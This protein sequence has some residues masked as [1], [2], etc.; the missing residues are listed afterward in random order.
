MSLISD[1]PGPSAVGENPRARAWAWAR[2]HEYRN[3]A[4]ALLAIFAA[5]PLLPRTLPFGLYVLGGVSAAGMILNGL[6]VALVY[7]VNRFPNFA[8]VALAAFAGTVFSS[9]VRGQFFLDVARS[10]CGCV[11]RD[12]KGISVTVNFLLAVVVGMATATAVSFGF[13]VIVLRRFGRASRLLL[14]VFTLFAAQL[15]SYSEG[16]VARLL[17]VEATLEG[18]ERI[19]VPVDFEWT[20]D[21]FA[22]LHLRDVLLV[23]LAVVAL[24]G[25]ARYLR[26]SD[27]G[28]AVNAASENPDRARSLGVDVVAVTSRVWILAGLLA[29]AAGVVGA[30]G[31]TTE[32][33]LG[34]LKGLVTLLFVAVVARFRS[35]AMLACAALVMGTLELAV[36]YSFGSR[37]P[38]D[39]VGVFLIGGVL[40][41]QRVRR[42]RADRDDASGFEVARE[43]RPIPAELRGL[44]Q[45]RAWVRNG[46][47]AGVLVLLGL[48]W[49]F[50]GRRTAEFTVFVIF[51]IVGL[52]LV[53]VTAWMGQ[54]SLGQFGFAA[55]GAWGAAVSGL[56][57]P[58]AVVV[59]GFL[60]AVAA[61]VVGLPALRLGGLTLA[62]STLAFATSAN[63]LFTGDRYLGQLLPATLERPRLLG[64]DLVDPRVFYYAMV[65]LT[66]ATAVGVMG[67]RRSHLGRALIGL[68]SNEAAGE[69][70]GLDPVRLRLTA[71]AISGFLAAVAGGLFAFHVGSV[72]SGSFDPTRSLELFVFSAIGGLGGVAGPVCGM[73]FMAVARS[74]GTNAIVAYLAV[75]LGGMLVLMA[76]PG[77]LAQLLYEARDSALRRVAM[78]LRIPVPSLMG[79]RGAAR[80][81]D[82]LPLDENR[83]AS[84][85]G[86]ALPLDYRLPNQWA[87]DRLAD[88]DDGV[89]PTVRA[90]EGRPT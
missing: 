33:R 43:P 38:Y 21:A 34:P 78:R 17:G 70:F 26:T 31:A 40:L 35:F 1:E 51:V 30:F 19:E 3:E 37:A 61:V 82:R 74:F 86:L 54:V 8:Q 23:A 76:A 75:G 49:V 81:F 79:E 77:G 68:R 28:T 50:S 87:L 6:A 47:A 90:F 57:M 18:A 42:T 13:Y 83:R 29:G 66:A 41:L 22:R 65:V 71:F 2:D 7:R 80:A 15:L 69:A 44:S 64:M 84:R 27:T 11:S 53:V 58:I 5:L 32:A 73:V 45:V 60:G 39:A 63:I 25:V 20:I 48:P 59:G 56:P 88:E 16:D 67:L 4:L 55:I 52:S 46:T 9:L 89:P 24:I 72:D 10:V 36:P 12:P 14:S 62:V 85:S